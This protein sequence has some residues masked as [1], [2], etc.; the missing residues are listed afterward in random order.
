MPRNQT[1]WLWCVIC[2]A[3]YPSARAGDEKLAELLMTGDAPG[4]TPVRRW[5]CLDCSLQLLGV[6]GGAPGVHCLYGAWVDVEQV[7]STRRY[8]AAVNAAARR[9]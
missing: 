5:V 1:R 2:G 9:R 3:D 4:L 7:D 8:I 6:Q